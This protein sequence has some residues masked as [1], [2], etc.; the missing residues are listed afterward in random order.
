MKRNIFIVICCSLLILTLTSPLSLSHASDKRNILLLTSCAPGNNRFDKQ[1]QGI[2]DSLNDNLGYNFKLYIEYMDI[3]STDLETNYSHFNDLLELKKDLYKNLDAIVFTD[4]ITLNFS[5]ESNFK[6]DNDIPKFFLGVNDKELIKKSKEFNFIGGVE[7]SPSIEENVEFISTISKDK[8]N[9]IFMAPSSSI[10]KEDI[11][12]FYSLSNKYKKLNFKHFYTPNSF[13]ENF[14]DSIKNLNKDNNILLFLPPYKHCPASFNLNNQTTYS[15]FNLLNIPIFN[16]YD[17]SG[18]DYCVG[19]KIIDSYTEGFKIGD[20][21]CRKLNMNTQNKYIKAEEINQWVFN[22]N[23]LKKLGIS[24]S[25]LPKNSKLIGEPL[26]LYKQPLDTLLPII[27][28]ITFLLLI[29]GGLSVHMFKKQKYEKELQKAK[30]H[31]EDMNIAKNNFISNISH[32]LR[33][34]V[35]VIA[36]SSQLL[37]HIL[38]KNTDVYSQNIGHN[39]DMIDQNSNRLLRLIN[40]I[41]DVAK[42]DSGIIDLNLQNTDIVALVEDTVLSI[43]P[44]AQIKNIDVVFDTTIEE[45]NIAVDI[46]KIERVLLN[47]LSNAIKFSNYNGS[48][49]AAVS[50]DAYN[51]RI[52]IRDTG[53]GIDNDH[54]SNIFQ[55]FMQVDNGFTRTNEGSG[56]GLSIVQSFI[57]L[58]KG[59]IFVD[60]VKNKGTTFTILLPLLNISEN[61]NNIF[62]SS[63]KNTDIELSDIYFDRYTNKEGLS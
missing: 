22:Y 25:S 52:Q 14:I 40:N 24:K 39:F 61:D 16:L 15:V 27:I 8:K 31:A 28:I 37:K 35:A 9:L 33:T 7:E 1:L 51:A 44:Y 21:I 60:S 6:F 36:S 38:E 54:L 55:K 4:D 62:L 57:Q 47:L 43:V 53:I 34:P 12:R 63:E 30:K 41:I 23:E 5:L 17:Y 20:L 49:Y 59:S 48:I 18:F 42:I 2:K 11:D 26:P 50:K 58:H 32:E 45:L 56:I 19:G 29:I 3:S 10:Y 13:D 46:E